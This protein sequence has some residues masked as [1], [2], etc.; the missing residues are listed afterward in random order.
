MPRPAH[1]A[2]PYGR[3]TWRLGAL[4]SALELIFFPLV[5]S[6]LY[7]VP[8][9]AGAFVWPSLPPVPQRRGPSCWRRCT[10]W[11]GGQPGPAR[12]SQADCNYVNP[13]LWGRAAVT[14]PTAA[15][16]LCI[17]ISLQKSHK[18]GQGERRGHR[19]CHRSCQGR[20]APAP[21]RPPPP[22][23]RPPT[24]PTLRRTA[25]HSR[26]LA[27]LPRLIDDD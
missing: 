20:L 27:L 5:S 21:Q 9:P 4:L 12:A 16:P 23:L 10:S 24:P 14:R 11:L 13:I 15:L 6:M 18:T 3:L 17:Y 22:K 25:A 1:S 8:L 26:P 19:R 2:S 7:Y